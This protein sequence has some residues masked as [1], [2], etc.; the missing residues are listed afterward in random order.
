[1]AGLGEPERE[2]LRKQARDWLRLGLAAW[3]KEVDTGTEADRIQAQMTLAPW[4]DDPDLAG[5]RD[6]NA[7]ERLPPAEREECR[8]HWQEVAAV[9]G[10]T[11]ATP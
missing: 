7:L 2:A 4:R 6:E 5:L 1:V 3:A 9:I 8:A 11:G 10:P